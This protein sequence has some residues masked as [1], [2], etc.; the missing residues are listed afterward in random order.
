MPQIAGSRTRAHERFRAPDFL[1]GLKLPEHGQALYQ[2]DQLQGPLCIDEVVDL[3]ASVRAALL[4]AL[5]DGDHGEARR[6]PTVSHHRHTYLVLRWLSPQVDEGAFA[7]GAAGPKRQVDTASSGDRRDPAVAGG[8]NLSSVDRVAVDHHLACP[9]VPGDH[10]AIMPNRCPKP[11][12][13]TAPYRR[14][15][16]QAV[17]PTRGVLAT[18]LSRRPTEGRLARLRS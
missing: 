6:L 5:A 3:A 10:I 14:E 15:W 16:V 7:S 13:R 11:T 8:S 1:I 4:A 2:V 9:S 18:G 17:L 12:T